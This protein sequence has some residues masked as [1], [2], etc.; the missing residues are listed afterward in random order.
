MNYIFDSYALQYMLEQFPKAIAPQIWENFCA[1]CIDGTIISERETKEKLIAE[2]IES[3]TLEWC[4]SNA[5]VFKPIG[6]KESIFLKGLMQSKEFNFLNTTDLA[7]RRIPEGL[8]FLLSIAKTQNRY[9]VYRKNTNADIMKRIISVC[10]NH[11]IRY[12][13]IEEFLVSCK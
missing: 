2:A 3:E 11:S 5:G 13:E 10:K 7:E 1:K 9:F 6:E 12:I 8:P 4:K